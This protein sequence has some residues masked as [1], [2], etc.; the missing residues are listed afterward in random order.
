MHVSALFIPCYGVMTD[1]S[2]F[3]ARG[4]LTD[5]IDDA[6]VHHVPVF[7]THQ[8]CCVAAVIDAKDLERLTRVAE[9]LADIEAAD[10]ARAEIAERGTVPWDEVG[11]DLEF[12]WPLQIK[13]SPAA[14]R[15]LRKMDGRTQ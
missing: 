2:V 4:R 15:M 9:D 6:R 12:D 8:D 10:A 13:P 7:L 1:M 3:V 5:V 11:A 14:A